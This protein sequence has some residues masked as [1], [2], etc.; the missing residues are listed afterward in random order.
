MPG[1]GRTTGEIDDGGRVEEERKRWDYVGSPGGGTKGCRRTKTAN[2]DTA[3]AWS[4]ERRTRGKVRDVDGER[5]RV[6]RERERE[7]EREIDRE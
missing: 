5:Q 1:G 6:E 7:T 3:K 4:S 2:V